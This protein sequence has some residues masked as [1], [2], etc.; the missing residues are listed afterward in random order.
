MIY[1][2]VTKTRMTIDAF[3]DDTGNSC[4]RKVTIDRRRK[5]ETNFS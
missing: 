2:R 1:N 3:D 4:C 5:R